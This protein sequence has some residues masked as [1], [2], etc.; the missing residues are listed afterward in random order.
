MRAPTQSSINYLLNL[1]RPEASERRS[2]RPINP[3]PNGWRQK[4]HDLLTSD[5]LTM[6]FNSDGSAR[7]LVQRTLFKNS[8]VQVNIGLVGQ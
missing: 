8:S 7:L 4:M 5:S 6:R 1:N 3:L 2:I